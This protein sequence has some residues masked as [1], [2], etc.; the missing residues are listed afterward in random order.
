LR[1]VEKQ[2][3]YSSSPRLIRKLLGTGTAKAAHLCPG[4]APSPGCVWR[5][6]FRFPATL[7]GIG[8]DQTAP[9]CKSRI[10][11][12]T[13]VSAEII[14]REPCGHCMETDIKGLF[15]IT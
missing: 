4:K 5:A 12:P 9:L 15:S 6:I 10:D 2:A 14:I 11:S 3:C 8:S 13:F 1:L 7:D